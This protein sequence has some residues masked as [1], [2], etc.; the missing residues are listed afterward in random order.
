M[1]IELLIPAMEEYMGALKGKP[2]AWVRAL[3]NALKGALKATQYKIKH[4]VRCM[5]FPAYY[6]TKIEAARVRCGIFSIALVPR[7]S[8]PPVRHVCS[9]P[10]SPDHHY[11]RNI[12]ALPNL[13]PT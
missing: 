8:L 2:P 3:E 11:R 9:R 1:F 10:S 13:H 4:P 7:Q 12:H 6:I 5:M